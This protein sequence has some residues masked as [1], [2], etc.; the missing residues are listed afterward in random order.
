MDEGSGLYFMRN[1]WYSPDLG[2][3]IQQDPIGLDGGTNLYAYTGNGPTNQTDPEGTEPPI[4][5]PGNTNAQ[6]N[7]IQAAK[8]ALNKDFGTQSSAQTNQQIQTTTQGAKA[9][10][11]ET[12]IKLAVPELPE[13]EVVANPLGNALINKGVNK[14]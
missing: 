8:D 4:G 2:R 3:F 12:L 11:V 7:E 13:L 5:T 1:R 10:A 6:I 14:G 9:A